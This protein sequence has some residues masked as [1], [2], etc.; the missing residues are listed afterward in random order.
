MFDGQA[1]V[2]NMVGAVAVMMI[3]PHGM[4]SPHPALT[5][6]RGGGLDLVP[7]PAELLRCAAKAQHVLPGALEPCSGGRSQSHLPAR[8]RYGTRPPQTGSWQDFTAAA[9]RYGPA[10]VRY[11]AL[12]ADAF[13]RFRRVYDRQAAGVS[14][15]TPEALLHDLGLYNETQQSCS[16][17]LQVRSGCGA[18]T[19]IVSL[20]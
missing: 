10:A 6:E 4:L 14:Y 11:T 2:L 8:V 3:A 20:S 17:Y 7:S 16:D 9:I 1:F 13:R 15:G 19:G 18:D 12:V 5:S